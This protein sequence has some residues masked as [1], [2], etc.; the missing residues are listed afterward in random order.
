VDAELAFHLEE[1]VEELLAQGLS[2]EAAEAEAARR[3]G[4][5]ARIREAVAAIDRPARRRRAAGEAVGAWARDVRLAWRVLLR[6][7]LHSA[8][9][10]LTL[11]LGIG[12]N[13]A[14][15]SALDAVLLRPLPS[16][17]GLSR[18][19]VLR[20][21]LPGLDLR[22]TPVSA[23]EAADLLAMGGPLEAAGAYQEG[24][25][26][27]QLDGGGPGEVRRLSVA[28]TLGDL[29]PLLGARAHLGRLLGPEDSADGAP[30]VVV[31]GHA[32]WRELSGGDPALL[33]RTLVLDGQAHTVVGVL[34]PDFRF[35]HGA[36]A[37]APLVLTPRVL[38]PER[39][40]SLSV[41]A[42]ARVREGVGEARLA[43]AL[44]V[45]AGRWHERLGPGVYPPAVGHTVVARPFAPWLAGELRGV[46]LVLSG[47][48]AFVLLV[49]C[50]NVA[51]LLLVRTVGRAREMAVRT[52][53]GAGRGALVRQLLVESLL[54]AAA[55]GLA[56]LA[57]GA[58]VV[59]AL[60]GLDPALFPQLR[61]L[62]LDGRVLGFTAAV[63]ALVAVLAGGAPALRA[64]RADPSDVLR[65][66]GRG[67]TGGP[68]RGRL[69]AASAVA[70]VALTAVLLLGAGL[71][72]QSLLGLLATDPGFRPQH[73]LSARV[74]LPR[75]RAGER[76]VASF[77]GLL[78]ELGARPGVEAAGAVSFLPFAGESDSSPFT[79]P[80]REAPAPGSAPGSGPGG[81]PAPHA[82]TRVV[83]GD[84][85]RAMG[86]PLLRGRLFDGGER[87]DGPLVALVDAEL[88][89]RHFPGE[90]PVGKVLEQGR[91]ATIIGVVGAVRHVS[92][93]E[94]PRPTVYYAH[95]QHP[96]HVSL[97]V[98]A[99]GA[100][101][102]EALEREVRAAA[103][104][105]A[106]GAPV[107]AVAPLEALVDRSLAPRR[108]AVGVLGG[109][110][111]LALVLSL[112]GLY[113]VVAYGARQ[114]TRELGIRLALGARPRDV[115]R[116]V[117]RGGLGLALAG[118]AVG[119]LL[120]L[121]LGR[122]LAASLSG[123]AAVDPWVA[124]AAA[125]LVALA[126]LLASWLPARR[127]ARTPP[128][129]ALRQE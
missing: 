89:R 118:L 79:L 107:H 129:L 77:A 17:P 30:R 69:L 78:G 22:Q 12:A 83:A 16:A 21:D 109:F 9:V 72:V 92:V 76:A 28:R 13:T 5:V 46:L 64:S 35:P 20:D 87:A 126:A 101:P 56:G 114:R 60:A 1:R 54:L 120:S 73:A 97:A 106:P 121:A 80:G 29:F 23:G 100:L 27:L 14:I 51:G 85:F 45:E 99:R 95:A 57:L 96:W 24:A 42:L 128:T 4:D 110:A 112:L 102:R 38:S 33:G 117:L 82:E 52:A 105:H 81:G 68:S 48:V 122:L 104:G 124:L 18:L 2:R 36:E 59:E 66:G 75:E 15:F 113:G 103:A 111:A 91:P 84:F 55:G 63:T 61:G 41:T 50:A 71:T 65:E 116:L 11:A 127:A 70:Q 74:S 37:Y 125:A 19:V 123:V 62:R 32:L 25:A 90:D 8:L 98:V 26:T 115:V 43:E 108:L 93:G 31:L 119:G 47:A 94:A 67:A 88:A 86:V 49:A 3:F 44:R 10:V 40:S 53:L 7:P 39:R 6:E 58:A 34:A